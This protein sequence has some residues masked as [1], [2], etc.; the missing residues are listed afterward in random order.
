MTEAPS[1]SQTL[2]QLVDDGLWGNPWHSLAEA[3]AD[4]EQPPM[5]DIPDETAARAVGSL[6]ASSSYGTRTQVAVREQPSPM[7][8]AFAALTTI[9][10]MIPGGAFFYFVATGRVPDWG[11]VQE[12][13]KFWHDKF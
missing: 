3:T 11:I 6:T 8:T 10:L 2:L 12:I 5:G 9:I 1:L 4:I 13:L 7:F